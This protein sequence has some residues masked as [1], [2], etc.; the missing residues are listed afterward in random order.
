MTTAST[1]TKTI[2][3]QYAEWRNEKGHLHREN[4]PAITGTND[5]KAWYV[6][7]KRH[8]LDGPAQIWRRNDVDWWV[9]DTKINIY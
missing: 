7:G 6:N 1:S 5:Y 9:N 8:R 4:G 3:G 2:I